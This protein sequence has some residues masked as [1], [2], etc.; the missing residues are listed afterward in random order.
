M[1]EP[2]AVLENGDMGP[3]DMEKRVGSLPSAPP[4][5]PLAGGAALPDGALPCCGGACGAPS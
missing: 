2:M 5:P 4:C 1:L 3:E